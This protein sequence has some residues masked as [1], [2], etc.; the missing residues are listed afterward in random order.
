M[1]SWQLLL[2][3]TIALALSTVVGVERQMNQKS[4]GIRTHTLVGVGAALFMVVSKYGFYDVAD[5][6][7]VKL[8][9]SHMAAQIVSG[10]G[11]VGAGLVFVRRN[12][13]RGLT[14]ASSIWLV[15]AI[16]SAAGAGLFI[17]AVFVTVVHFLVA[18]GY[19]YIVRR[20]RLGSI[21][22]HTV[23]VQYQ[24][25]TGALR[26]ILLAC[27]SQ[28]LAVHGFEMHQA[29]EPEDPPEILD[30]KVSQNGSLLTAGNVVEVELE[31]T[32]TSS[33]PKLVHALSSLDGI[34][35]V[36]VDDSSD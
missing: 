11:F 35:S 26:R 8:E 31:L 36:S 23:R 2:C 28:G 9:P 12:R 16:G 5:A 13:V 6:S 20:T 4:A 25:G 22:E 1:D 17:P 15:A 14:T 7:L 29:L 34:K 3:L 30:R 21:R 24:D 32:G 18:L 33:P 27:T 19:P 10:I